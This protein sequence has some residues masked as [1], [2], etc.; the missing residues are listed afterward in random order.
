MVADVR[1]TPSFESGP[2]AP[3][4]KVPLPES[5]DRQYD[6]SPDG[7]RFLANVLS[8]TTT[9]KP[10]TVVLNWSAAIEKK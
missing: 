7:T 5:P 4:F 9:V 8:G 3:L 1:L 2:P 6:V 10:L